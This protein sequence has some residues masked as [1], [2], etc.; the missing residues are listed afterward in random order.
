MFLYWSTFDVLVLEYILCVCIGVHL[1]CL[2]WSTF[3][4]LVLEYI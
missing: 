1:M 3:D 4:V 2:Y